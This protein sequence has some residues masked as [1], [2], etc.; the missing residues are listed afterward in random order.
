M[1]GNDGGVREGTWM[2][3]LGRGVGRDQGK[4][5]ESKEVKVLMLSLQ[6]L[7]LWKIWRIFLLI[8]GY[9]SNIIHSLFIDSI[10]SLIFIF[11]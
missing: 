7:G 8:K 10:F 3:F 4:W 2:T 6:K 9:F 11:F 5:R 1:R